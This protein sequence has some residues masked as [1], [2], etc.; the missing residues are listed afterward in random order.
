[1]A[2]H[3]FFYLCKELGISHLLFEAVER[4]PN[5]VSFSGKRCRIAV[6]F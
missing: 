4:K 1:M 2:V 3:G 5:A 6:R